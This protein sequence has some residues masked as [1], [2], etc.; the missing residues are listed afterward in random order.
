MKSR[1][2]VRLL[3]AGLLILSGRLFVK[4]MTGV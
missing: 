3:V 4:G 1:T 2:I